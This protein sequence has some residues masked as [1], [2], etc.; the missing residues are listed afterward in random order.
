MSLIIGVTMKQDDIV[1]FTNPMPDE[2]GLTMKVLEIDGSWLLVE[3]L[4][5]MNINPTGIASLSEVEPA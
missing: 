1:K 3:Y 2:I 4:V 5:G